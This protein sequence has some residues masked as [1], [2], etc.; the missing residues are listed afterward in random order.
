MVAMDNPLNIGE[1]LN[2]GSLPSS[3]KW[4]AWHPAGAP[5]H[6]D[7]YCIPQLLEEENCTALWVERAQPWCRS[8]EFK[9][10][11]S[12]QYEKLLKKL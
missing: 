10:A 5:L 9:A 2:Y 4:T 11:F 12:C 6:C 7:E 8:C 3:S 1:E